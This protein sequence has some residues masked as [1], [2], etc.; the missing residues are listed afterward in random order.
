MNRDDLRDKYRGALLGVA[1]GDVLGAD[2][3]FRG[4]ISRNDLEAHLG[5]STLLDYTDDTHMTLGLAESLIECSGFDGPHLAARFAKR[6][7]AEPWRGYG[8]SPPRIFRMLRDGAPWDVPART[9]F[10]EG[11]SFGN[12]A[13]MRVAPAA[14]F[15]FPD[16]DA[17]ADMARQASLVTHTHPLGVEGAILQACAVAYLLAQRPDVPLEA[18]ALIGRV[19]GLLTGHEYQRAL[20]DILALLPDAEPGAVASRLGNDVVAHR[21]VPA[22]VYAFLH[23]PTSFVGTVTYA[24][25]LGGDTDTIAAMAGALSGAYLGERAIPDTL[26]H[27]TEGVAELRALADQLFEIAVTH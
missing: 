7:F 10:G 15:A 19:R 16:L 18:T 25:S 8:A 20:D 27:R 11:G 21:S 24:I 22:A 13:A 6:Y 12:G 14:L 2:F 23:S 26:L 5:S 9:L 3:E 1:V 4:P 17:V